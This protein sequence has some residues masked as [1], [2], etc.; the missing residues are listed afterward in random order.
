MRTIHLTDGDADVLEGTYLDVRH[1]DR[2]IRDNTTVLKPDGTPLL[3]YALN[4]IPDNLWRLG[5]NCGKDLPLQSSNR[6]AAAGGTRFRPVKRDRTRSHTVQAR[7]VPSGVVGFLDRVSRNQY[8][9]MSTLTLDHYP[10]FKAAHPFVEAVSQQFERLAPERWAAQ[11]RFIDEVSPDFYIPNTVFTTFTV[12]RNWR[13]A[14]HPDKGDYRPGFGVMM[15]MGRFDGG[16]LI[17]PKF[18]TAV[19]M[20]PGGLLLAD[21]HELHGNGLL[22]VRAPHQRLSFVF[23]ARENMRDCGSAAEE[24]ERVKRIGGQ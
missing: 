6:I 19:D 4:A 15:A 14:A 11:R 5:Y 1:Y 2:I 12:N 23:Y 8:C 18:R 7:P 21:V 17:F 13:T 20:R 24:L 22:D 9:R 16:E 3:I 10:A